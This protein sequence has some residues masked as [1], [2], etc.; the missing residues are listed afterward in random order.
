MVNHFKRLAMVLVVVPAIILAQT[1]TNRTFPLV[2]DSPHQSMLAQSLTDTDII[3][4]RSRFVEINSAVVNTSVISTKDT[5]KL[6]LF[7]D[8]DFIAIV[9]RVKEDVNGTVSIRARIADYEFGY[10]LLSATTENKIAGYISIP[11]RAERYVIR[12]MV[13][14]GTQQLLEVKNID[15][16]VGSPPIVPDIDEQPG[17]MSFNQLQGMDIQDDLQPVIIDIM[18][19]YTPKAKEWAQNYGGG[20]DNVVAMAMERANLVLDN[21]NTLMNIS[22]V[23]SG[24]VDYVEDTISA[25]TDLKRLRT[26]DDGYMDVVHDLRDLYGADLVHLFSYETQTGGLG[27]QLDCKNGKPEMGFALSRIQQ[28]AWSYTF[29]HELGHNM[30]AH[31]RADQEHQPGPTQWNYTWSDNTWSAGWR[32][33]GNDRN[34]YCSVMSYNDPWDGDSVIWVPHFSNPDINYQETPTGDAVYADNARTLREIRHVIAGYRPAHDAPRDFMATPSSVSQIDLTWNKKENRDI[35]LLYSTDSLFGI[36]ENEQYYLEGDSINGGGTV[37]YAGD[38]ESFSHNGLTPNTRYYYKI[39]SKISPS[40]QWSALGIKTNAITDSVSVVFSENF[41]ATDT[42]PFGWETEDHQGYGRMW[43]FGT[44]SDGLVRT[45]GNYAYLKSDGSG[46][47][48]T[49]NADLIT[50]SLDFSAYTDLTL[51]FTYYYSH[52]DESQATLSYSIDGGDW[53]YISQ[54]NPETN[55][56]SSL[57]VTLSNFDGKRDVRF[58]WNYTGY[59]GHL[60]VDDIV[61]T[62]KELIILGDLYHIYDGLEKSATVLSAPEDSQI[63]L[64]YNGIDSLPVD[65]G[66]YEVIALMDGSDSV[67]I[68]DTLVI[69]P[70]PISVAAD[71]TG[72]VY[73]EDDPE[74]TYTASDLIGDDQFTGDLSRDSGENVGTYD[75]NQGSVCAGDNYHIYFRD[76]PFIINPRPITIAA[77]SVRKIYGEKDPELT[78]SIFSGDLL[79]DDEITGVLSREPGEST[80]SYRVLQG[81]LGAGDNYAISFGDGFFIISAAPLTITANDFV[82]SEGDPEPLFTA[83]YDGFVNDDDTSSI[84]MPKFRWAESDTAG[85]Y[86][87]EPYGAFAD[88]Y[89]ISYN[90]GTLTIEPVTSVAFRFD[91]KPDNR[92][93]EYGILL[94]QNPVP[95]YT[96]EVRF[97][98]VNPGHSAVKVAIYDQLGTLLFKDDFTT[99]RTGRSE[100]IVWPMTNRTGRKIS[101]GTYLIR[102]E[103]QD[104][105]TAERYRYNALVGVSR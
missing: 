71:S 3:E 41:D 46:N 19:V 102:V 80:G 50:P 101:T 104:K 75:I 67:Q 37:L 29:I 51:S 89:D 78:Y 74:L 87:I 21:S 31:H 53:T 17:L 65:A 45:T 97:K 84:T 85:T 25:D 63:Q 73:G 27:Y 93:N 8:R 36:P 100:P 61:V 103:A 34:R 82:I 55:N 20:I 40:P 95:I 15:V 23:Y 105:S 49:V 64:T 94:E 76:A 70:R 4:K 13:N 72:K 91:S 81:D 54:W 68:S 42:I 39:Y 98:V 57:N 56:P 6:N 2:F 48:D 24:M 9:D 26:P 22:L 12:D 69:N 47:G 79:G 10:I 32:W 92:G 30:G 77:D 33:I 5:L 58:K 7:E 59:N 18:V 35:L 66:R 14:T 11:E 1:H 99:D 16:L 43:N 83:T 52:S 60:N 88:N 44:H 28:A 62:G 38:A 86:D 90:F 96:N